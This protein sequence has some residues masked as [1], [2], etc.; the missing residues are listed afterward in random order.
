MHWPECGTNYWSISKE[1]TP[2]LS[3]LLCAVRYDFQ[4]CVLLLQTVSVLVVRNEKWFYILETQMKDFILKHFKSSNS[5]HPSSLQ[6]SSLIL[7]SPFTLM[8]EYL[9][10][11]CAFVG[12]SRPYDSLS[13]TNTTKWIPS[14]SKMSCDIY[15]R[16]P[17][18]SD[19]V[20][21]REKS[22]WGRFQW[23]ALQFSVFYTI[24]SP[25]EP[26]HHA[27]LDDHLWWTR[28]ISY[29]TMFSK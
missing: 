5:L 25:A 12:P 20:F 3:K 29:L 1:R 8:K 15:W 21:E 24:V 10:W 13:S 23:N 6:F 28:L 7:N 27:S 26:L 4:S 9:K 19:Q 16:V 11:N 18:I 22:W 14:T 17:L 2:S